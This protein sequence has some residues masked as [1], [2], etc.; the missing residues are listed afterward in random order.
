MVNDRLLLNLIYCQLSIFSARKSKLVINDKTFLVSK[1][2]MSL[3]N[4]VHV[5]KHGITG[6]PYSHTNFVVRK[7]VF[8]VFDLVPHKLGCTAIE[9]GLRLEIS[10]IGSRGIVLSM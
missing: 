9:D 3:L 6:S 2:E 4:L 7:P 5:R 8:G 1:N 10:D